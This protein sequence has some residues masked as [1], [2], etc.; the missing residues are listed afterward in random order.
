M[1]PR[2]RVE[3]FLGVPIAAQR[4]YGHALGVSPDGQ[5]TPSARQASPLRASNCLLVQKSMLVFF[6]ILLYF[7]ADVASAVS[8]QGLFLLSCRLLYIFWFS[9]SVEVVL[10]GEWYM[11][12]R[13]WTAKSSTFSLTNM[14]LFICVQNTQLLFWICCPGLAWCYVCWWRI[15]LLRVCAPL[16][17]C[18]VYVPH[19]LPL[20]PPSAPRSPSP[21]SQ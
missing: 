1:L 15:P 18:S 3:A 13:R 19:S 6:Y 4:C 11:D 14:D 21:L 12:V 10:E 7:R 5:P 8:S 16:V 2:G 9:K 20:H 17:T